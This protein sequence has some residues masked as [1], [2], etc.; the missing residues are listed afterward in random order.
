MKHHKLLLLFLVI[1]FFTV[2]TAFQVTGI[3]LPAE[4]KIQKT[5]TG[6]VALYNVQMGDPFIFSEGDTYYLYGTSS[7]EGIE[8]FT[9]KDLIHWDGPMGVTDGLALHRNDVFGEKWFWAPEVYKFQGKYYMFYSAEEHI[10]VAVSSSPLGPFTQ[11][12]QVPLITTKAIDTHLFIDDDG[13]KY[14][15]YVAFSNGN[16]IWMCEMN[17][18]LLSIKPETV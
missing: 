5:Q 11:E 13:K 2:F 1:I 15:Y 18:D 16:V 3:S 4:T 17:D 10:A 8:V 7:D 6:E 12:K 14:L 9:S